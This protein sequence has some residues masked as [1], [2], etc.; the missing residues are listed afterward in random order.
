MNVVVCCLVD[1]QLARPIDGN[2]KVKGAQGP[3]WLSLF[4]CCCVEC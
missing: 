2:V 4:L 1:D 3:M